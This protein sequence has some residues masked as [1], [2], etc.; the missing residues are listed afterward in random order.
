MALTR[1]VLNGYTLPLIS[2]YSR[3]RVPVEETRELSSGT[4]ARYH[5]GHRSVFNLSWS[6]VHADALEVIEQVGRIRGATQFID[7]DGT[8]YVV[9]VE[10]LDDIV[11]IPGTE[12]E[13][14]AVGIRLTERRP[15]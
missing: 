2:R 11:P 9:L 4:V 1:A 10:E 15:R 7:V 8:P 3:K 13:K 5:R 14:Y 12:P 6:M